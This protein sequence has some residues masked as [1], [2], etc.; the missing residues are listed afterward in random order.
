MINR[1][2]QWVSVNKKLPEPD[3]TMPWGSVSVELYVGDEVRSPCWYRYDVKR[4]IS[5]G[6]DIDTIFVTHWRLPQ[7]PNDEEE[8]EL[9]DDPEKLGYTD[10]IFGDQ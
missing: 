5:Y 9:E 4:W 8:T 6:E 2:E 7:P 3:K 1:K 10:T